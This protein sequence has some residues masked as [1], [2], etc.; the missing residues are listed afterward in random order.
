MKKRILSLFLSALLMITPV[1]ASDV[2]GHWAQEGISF[3]TARELFSG[4]GNGRFA[5]DDPM[6][7]AMLVTVASR[8]AGVSLSPVSETGF[9][10][11][12]PDAWYAPAVAW[13]SSMHLVEGIGNGLFA[14]ENPVTRVEFATILYRF[15]QDIG[16]PMPDAEASLDSYADAEDVPDWGRDG[17]LWAVAQGII[18]G[19]PGNRLDPLANATRAEVAT[20]IMRFYYALL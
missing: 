13:A 2:T 7:R 6:T 14:P 12:A 16:Y 9:S 19:K 10:D 8:M 5:P 20:M 15:L 3:V 1:A 18:A 17:M 4:V 11:V